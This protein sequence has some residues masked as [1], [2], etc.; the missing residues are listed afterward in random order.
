MS[1]LFCKYCNKEYKNALAHRKHE[2][3]CKC[4]NDAR[5]EEY[6]KNNDIS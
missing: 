3:F 4:V 6:L 1:E 2:I 5:N